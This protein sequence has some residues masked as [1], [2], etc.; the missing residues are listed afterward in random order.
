M[1]K[2]CD[3]SRAFSLTFTISLYNHY[4]KG[5]FKRLLYVTYN[6]NMFHVKH[7]GKII[8]QSS[9]QIDILE[10]IGIEYLRSN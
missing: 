7:K 10:F 6:N 9:R 2:L 3:D 4:K 8:Y 5:D 1:N